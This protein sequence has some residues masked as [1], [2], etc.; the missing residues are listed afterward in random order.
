MKGS[1]I[2]DVPTEPKQNSAGF[3]SPIVG[4]DKGVQ[5]DYD[6]RNSMIFWVEGKENDDENVRPKDFFLLT[7]SNI[8]LLYSSQF[9]QLHTVEVI[10]HNSWVSILAL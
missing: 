9:G 4:I 10:K 3:I 8:H 6:R 2:I 1:Q 5:I 7:V